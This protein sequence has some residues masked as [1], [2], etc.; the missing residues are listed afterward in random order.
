MLPT[1]VLFAVW[2]ANVV[3]LIF[4]LVKINRVTRYFYTPEQRKGPDTKYPPI[5]KDWRPAH[6]A[7]PIPKSHKSHHLRRSYGRH[8]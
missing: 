7:L 1:S 2:G 6:T 4:I 8:K 3:L 5:P